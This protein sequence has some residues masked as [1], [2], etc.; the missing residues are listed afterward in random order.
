MTRL[1]PMADPL[2]EQGGELLLC[3]GRAMLKRSAHL[4]D[5]AL[6]ERERE[7]AD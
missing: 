1:E 3:E 2:A 4:Q 6:R 7:A 5:V